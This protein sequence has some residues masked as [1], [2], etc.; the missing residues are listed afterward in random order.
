MNIVMTT[1]T[2]WPR[3]NGVTIS[4]D[5]FKREFE[6]LGINAYVF[7]PDYPED[8]RDK[9]KN[10]IGFKT[11]NVFRFTSMGLFFD[12]EDRLVLPTS[13]NFMFDQFDAVKPDVVHIQTEFTTSTLARQ[14][15]K[16]RKIP[17]VMTCHT[18]F[19]QYINFY[20]PF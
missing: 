13:K 3:I 10:V 2:Y 12:K 17:I 15:C 1:D 6:K 9:G 11:G 5:T 16:S 7:A 8:N 4:I 14:Y 20:L 18:Y 19:E